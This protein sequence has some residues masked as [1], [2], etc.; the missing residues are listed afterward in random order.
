MAAVAV[1]TQNVIVSSEVKSPARPLTT[2]SLGEGGTPSEPE[3]IYQAVFD[4][5]V[6]YCYYA[7]ATLDATPLPSETTPN[8]TNNLSGFHEIV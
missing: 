5:V 1:V 4:T 7:K 6:G 3:L 8:H 2:V